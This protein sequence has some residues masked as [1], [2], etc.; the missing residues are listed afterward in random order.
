VVLTIGLVGQF[1][2]EIGRDIVLL[3]PA[4]KCG[5]RLFQQM[6]GFRKTRLQRCRKG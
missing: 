2:F 6:N 1:A 4:V 5:L 3:Q